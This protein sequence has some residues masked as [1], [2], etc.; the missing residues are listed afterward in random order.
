MP[1]LHQPTAQP[2]PP[3]DPSISQKQ[4]QNKQ[5]V[6]YWY[7]IFLRLSWSHEAITVNPRQRSFPISHL[8]KV[9]KGICKTKFQAWRS[10][11][12]SETK[13]A[14]WATSMLADKELTWNH[15]DLLWQWSNHQQ[16]TGNLKRQ[17][18]RLNLQLDE[19][20]KYLAYDKFHRIPGK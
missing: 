6:T 16:S 12:N 19:P 7:Y 5:E 8:D 18:K 11:L 14:T 17:Q 3:Y 2:P 15:G 1:P 20:Q 4:R 10:D 9:S 13:Y